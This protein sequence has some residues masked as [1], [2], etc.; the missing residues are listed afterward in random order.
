[1]SKSNDIE[2][3]N[4]ND[5][6]VLSH[7]GYVGKIPT[8]TDIAIDTKQDGTGTVVI[9]AYEYVGYAIYNA[10]GVVHVNMNPPQEFPNVPEDKDT[11]IRPKCKVHS[12]MVRIISPKV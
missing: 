8:R 6:L 7:T 11:T 5:C 10:G 3:V 12:E 4:P 2:I 1:M 9:T